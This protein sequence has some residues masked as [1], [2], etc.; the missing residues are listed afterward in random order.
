M[1]PALLIS[2]RDWLLI[3]AFAMGAINP[4][5]RRPVVSVT[6]KV[7]KA[8]SHPVRHPAKDLKKLARR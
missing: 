6:V 1:I 5:I 7:A 3:L 4:Y 8:V 2:V